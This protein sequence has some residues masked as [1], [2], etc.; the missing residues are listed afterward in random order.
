V[1][2]CIHSGSSQVTYNEISMVLVS[3]FSFSQCGGKDVLKLGE[4]NSIL[5]A[6]I[7]NKKEMPRLELETLGLLDLRANQLR[8][9]SVGLLDFR[10]RWCPN[11]N[12]R[13]TVIRPEFST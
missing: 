2:I 11:F 6:K 10:W 7:L 3:H 4:K 9:T 13:R 1:D 8:H 5:L 12:V